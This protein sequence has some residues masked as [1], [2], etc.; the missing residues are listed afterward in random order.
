MG[1]GVQPHERTEG[2]VV[3]DGDVG[4]RVEGDVGTHGHVLADVD[5]SQMPP[6]TGADADVSHD[7]RGVVDVHPHPPVQTPPEPTTSKRGQHAK[8]HIHQ[9]QP[10]MGTVQG[11]PPHPIKGISRG[12]GVMRAT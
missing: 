1:T 2:D 4:V 9:R 5:H 12:H 3:T 7:E 8:H 6:D 10:W 11:A